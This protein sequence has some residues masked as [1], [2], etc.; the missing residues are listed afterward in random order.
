MHNKNV[1]IMFKPKYFISAACVA[2]CLSAAAKDN[3]AVTET[4]YTRSSVYSMLLNH[5]EQKFSAE[6]LSQFLNI[7]VP[8]Q[9]NDHDLSVKVI[10][11]SKKAEYKDSIT[12]FIDRNMIASRMV[13]KWFDRNI[14]TG[15]CSMDLVKERGIYNAS[16]LDKEIAS[17]SKRG[18]AMLED[19]GEELIGKTFLLVNE[20]SYVD[21]GKKTKIAGGILRFAGAAAGMFLGSSISNL[22]DNLASTIESLKGF[23]V[24]IKTHL[25]QLV[26]DES[27]ASTFYNY[28]WTAKPDEGKKN[29]FEQNR[30]NFKLKYVGMVESS[31]SATSFMGIN[32][33]EPLLMVRK[34][35]QRAIDENVVD[36]QREYDTFR[37]KASLYVQDGAIKSAIGKKE[38]ISDDTKFEVLEAEEKD[39]RITYKRIGVIKP[40]KNK[41][42]DNRYMASEE[43]AYGADFGATTFEKESGKDP[44]DGVLIRRIY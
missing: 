39:G 14:L 22:T 20:I 17:R 6:I 2:L 28:C 4:K 32:E 33:Q 34:A 25:Y 36:L 27:T 29:A 18:I 30:S 31:G 24:K 12:T 15:E 21:K 5:V 40:I 26:W 37:V 1:D 19:A 41:I 8:D 10:N 23:K 42:W 38:G 44:Y 3:K 16:E 35:C 13:S 43:K 7:P 9:Y 11:V